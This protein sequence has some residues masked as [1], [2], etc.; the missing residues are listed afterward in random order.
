MEELLEW[1][2]F[3]RGVLVR[4]IVVRS[5]EYELNGMKDEKRERNFV[6]RGVR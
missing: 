1:V 3:F 2:L 4:E 6:W 5:R